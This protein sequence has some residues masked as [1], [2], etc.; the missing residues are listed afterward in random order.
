LQVRVAALSER[1]ANWHNRWAE[2]GRKLAD[3]PQEIDG[4]ALRLYGIEGEDRRMMEAEAGA[5]SSPGG[6]E[7]EPGDD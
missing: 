7:E 1:T 2:A 4:I 3:I 6:D 5:A